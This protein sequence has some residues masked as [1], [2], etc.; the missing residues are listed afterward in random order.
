MFGCRTDEQRRTKGSA[1]RS[2]TLVGYLPPAM[3]QQPEPKK[4]TPAHA[5]TPQKESGF[6]RSEM[7]HE[8]SE[9]QRGTEDGMPRTRLAQPLP[10][11]PR[12]M[13]SNCFGRSEWEFV[14]SFRDPR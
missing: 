1:L 9:E 7:Q 10:L 4:K 12:S 5:A 2:I 8:W 11:K 13:Q 6:P 14:R 3:T